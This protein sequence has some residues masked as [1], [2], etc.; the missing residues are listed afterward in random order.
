[1]EERRAKMGRPRSQNPM[2]HTAVV[3]PKELIQRLKADGE[4]SGKGLS[5]E[6]RRRLRFTYEL[7]TETAELVNFLK[8]LA[9]SL[10]DDFGKKWHENR[11][12]KDAFLAGLEIFAE[13]YATEQGVLNFDHRHDDPAA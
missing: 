8:R 7:D 11:Y 6:I 5:G 1:M 9:A 12:A 10:A 2:V 3:L 4:R 13:Q